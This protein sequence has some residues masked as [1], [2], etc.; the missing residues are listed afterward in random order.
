MEVFHALKVALP[1]SLLLWGG[2]VYGSHVLL[3]AEPAISVA[4]R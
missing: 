3:R 1:L 2:L 4:Q